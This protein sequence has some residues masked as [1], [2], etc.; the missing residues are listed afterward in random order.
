MSVKHQIEIKKLLPGT[1]VDTTDGKGIIEEIRPGLFPYLIR[2]D[3][4]GL[5]WQELYHIKSIIKV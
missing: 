5:A 4:G 1:Y 3:S 2:L